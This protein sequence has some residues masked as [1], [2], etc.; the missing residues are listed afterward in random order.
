MQFNFLLKVFPNWAPS[1]REPPRQR[2]R[3]VSFSHYFGGAP[4]Y[5]LSRLFGPNL[6]PRR[7]ALEPVP[8]TNEESNHELGSGPFCGRKQ[9][10]GGQWRERVISVEHSA[11]RALGQRNEI[12]NLF[13]SRLA[14]ATEPNTNI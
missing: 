8:A 9:W 11:I 3:L 5:H 12:A 2:A 14:R 13:F 7:R 10:V 4:S 6:S 1:K